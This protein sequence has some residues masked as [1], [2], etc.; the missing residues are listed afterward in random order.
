MSIQ[1]L[2]GKQ[3][4]EFTKSNNI[5]IINVTATWCGP[6]QMFAP[7][8]EEVSNNIPVV[9]VDLDQNREFAQDMGVKGVPTTFIYKDGKISDT[10]VG[11]MP[12]EVLEAKINN[13]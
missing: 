10:V 12:K 9:K 8:L 6:C 5:A 4:I 3:A 11:Y 13:I 1:H 2:D 7:I